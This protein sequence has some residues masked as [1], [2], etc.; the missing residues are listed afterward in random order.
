MVLICND[1]IFQNVSQL[2]EIYGDQGRK[3]L[4]ANHSCKIVFAPNEQEDA[5]YFSKEIAYIT[6]QSH[7]KSRNSQKTSVSRGQSESDAKRALMLPQELKQ[8]TFDEEIVLLNGENP[9]RCQKALYFKDR[10]FMDKLIALSPTLQHHTSRANLPSQQN[11][12]LALS[13]G[14]LAVQFDDKSEVHHE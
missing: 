6:T 7:S 10:Y 8:L 13:Q 9:I 14:E 4:L 1:Y 3:T 2:N 5:E 11:L 12:I